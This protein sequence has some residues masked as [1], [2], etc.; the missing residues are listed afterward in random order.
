MEF[1]KKFLTLMHKD[2]LL[3]IEVPYAEFGWRE[4]SDGAKL[5]HEHINMFKKETFIEMG[6]VLGLK[7]LACEIQTQEFLLGSSSKVIRCVMKG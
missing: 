1:M 3:Y 6:K 7:V 4:D 2:S 5:I